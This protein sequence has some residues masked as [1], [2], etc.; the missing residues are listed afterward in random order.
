MKITVRQGEIQKHRDEAIV[1]NLFEGV[2]PGGATG[3]VDKGLGGLIAAAIDCGDFTGAKNDTLLLYT[4]GRIP[5]PRVLVVGLGDRDKFDLEIARQAAA[6]AARRLQDLGIDQATTILHGTG[7]GGLEV[8]DAAQGVAEASILACYQ[9]GL[10]RKPKKVLK[11]LTLLEFDGRKLTAARRGAR[12]GQQIAEATCLARDLVHQP[13]AVATPTALAS[14]ARRIA[15]QFGL[16][17]KVVD[18]SGMKKLGM[19]LLLGVSRGSA[20]PAR[21]I[22]LE[23]KPKAAGPPLVFVGKGLTFDSGGLS[24]KSSGG[25]EGMKADMAGGAAV[26]GALQAVAALKLPVPVVGIVA[27]TENM[28]D[29]RAM[30]PGEVVTAMSGKTVE[31]LNTDAEGRLVLADALCYAGRY[32][33]AGVVDLATLTGACVTALG[34][35]ASGLLANDDDLA[36]RVRVAGEQTS[37]RVW[38]L[39]LWDEYREQLKSDIADLKNIGGRA[40]GT[41]TA[42]AFLSEFA[43]DYPWVHLDVAGTALP[44]KTGPYVP[45]GPGGIGVRLLT[46]LA[47]NW[48]KKS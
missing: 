8:E 19:N 29:G 5:A 26:L 45:K 14:T 35:H 32:K 22:I 33:P 9:F 16:K 21:L 38:Q 3:A 13:S 23:Y 28:P 44:A 47:R 17:C 15:R 39:P 31:V 6:T 24:L 41:I 18:E 48:R 34:H 2:R 1:V 11:K 10:Y 25:M 42:G 27:A 43:A 20:E 30:R 40:A 36:E 37:E 12:A 7:A 46:E 4:Q